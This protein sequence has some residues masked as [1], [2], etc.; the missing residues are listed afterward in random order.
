MKKMGLLGPKGTHSEEAAIYLK[1]FLADEVELII[2]SEIFEVL[3]AVEEGKIDSGFVPVENSL[4][5]SINITLDTLARTDFLQVTHELIWPIHNYLMTKPA[6]TEIKKIFSHAQPISQCRKYLRKNFPDAEIISTSSTARAAEIVAQ[7]EIFDGAAAICTKRAGELN[8][9]VEVAA[10]IQDNL[11]NSTRFFEVERKNFFD[12]KNLHGDKI[13]IICQIDGKKSG[14][15]Y[16]ILEEFALRK[17][18]MTRI[19]SRP[20]RTKLG[21]YIF[22]FDLE[23]DIDEKILNESVEAVRKKSIWLKNLGKFPVISAQ[24]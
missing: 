8:N 9:L 6:V 16:E 15:L 24:K 5:G 20:A 14:A 1:K 3:S 17:V 4:E 13:L 12:E 18:N 19:E 23:T 22:F 7:S 2:F 11:A 21:E 10:E